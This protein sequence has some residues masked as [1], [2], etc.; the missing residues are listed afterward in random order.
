MPFQ[1]LS[2]LYLVLAARYSDALSIERRSNH[3][4]KLPVVHST[5]RQVFAKVYE[6]KRAIATVPLEKRADVAYYA[7]RLFWFK[8]A[9]RGKIVANSL[10]SK[11][12]HATPARLCSVRHRLI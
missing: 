10:Q 7:K 12:R 1:L 3:Y 9:S 4:V 6:D 2:F 5:N 8:S 11:H